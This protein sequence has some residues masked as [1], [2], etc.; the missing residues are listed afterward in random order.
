[1][2]ASKIRRCPSK[3]PKLFQVV[4]AQVRKSAEINTVLH[5][6]LDVLTEPQPFQP[7]ANI[8]RH[9]RL[10][11]AWDAAKLRGFSH[12]IYWCGIARRMSLWGQKRKSVTATRMSVSGGEADEISA[13]PDITSQVPCLHDAL[14]PR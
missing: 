6:C 11:L 4:L 8:M 3:T 1:M 12:L 7:L 5:K 13:K 9:N 2:A 10:I 14:K